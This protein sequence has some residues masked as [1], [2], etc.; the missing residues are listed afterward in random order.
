MAEPIS[1]GGGVSWNGF[2]Y[3]LEDKA[4]WPQDLKDHIASGGLMAKQ[5]TSI[6]DS[7]NSE[8]ESASVPIEF[9]LEGQEPAPNSV[10]ATATYGEGFPG[11]FNTDS[12]D[13]SMMCSLE[14]VR[15]E[16]HT[17]AP[18][19]AP[20]PQPTPTPAPTIACRNI[21]ER[22][23]FGS[24]SAL[25]CCGG[26]D[27]E[28]QNTGYSTCI[29]SD[30]GCTG[31]QPVE[32]GDR[33]RIELGS[34]EHDSYFVMMV[35]GDELSGP[36]PVSFST[37]SKQTTV[38]TTVAVSEACLNEDTDLETTPTIAY[39][40]DDSYCTSQPLASTVTAFA[41]PAAPLFIHVHSKDAY[42]G[43]KTF[44]LAITC[45]GAYSPY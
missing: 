41:D 25:S 13:E 6:D 38:D 18:T 15:I 35:P 16:Q 30:M 23:Y 3:P 37:C 44:E 32:C 22:C 8:D 7:C 19:L 27:C 24:G 10:L 39:A 21:G 17:V 9:E 42:S 12:T 34:N 4:N 40:D 33:I 45:G 36:E 29:L 14:G 5:S 28:I 2:K 1:W 11:I 26:Y 31:A 20:S 43:T